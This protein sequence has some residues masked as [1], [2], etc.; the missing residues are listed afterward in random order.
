M[1]EEVEEILTT[2]SRGR[3]ESGT[4]T[5][6][7]ALGKSLKGLEGLL[8]RHFYFSPVRA[9]LPH[10]LGFI[11]TQ[12]FFCESKDLAL[13]NVRGPQRRPHR[14]DER[15]GI[16]APQAYLDIGVTRGHQVHLPGLSTVLD[17]RDPGFVHSVPKKVRPSAVLERVHPHA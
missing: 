13:V 2:I 9:D 11:V 7:L 16:V 6:G 1:L 14:A 3:I 4:Q 5:L 10:S 8:R 12:S 17:A 15:E